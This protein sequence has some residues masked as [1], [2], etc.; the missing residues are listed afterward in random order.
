MEN[1]TPWW[2]C[3]FGDEWNM[4]TFWAKHIVIIIWWI[5]WEARYD[6]VGYHTDNFLVPLKVYV[7]KHKTIY[8]IFG[9][10]TPKSV[11]L[12][13]ETSKGVKWVQSRINFVRNHSTCILL[14]IFQIKAPLLHNYYET[15]VVPFTSNSGTS[16]PWPNYSFPWWIQESFCRY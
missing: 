15:V 9:M 10:A 5:L 12:W 1:L 2:A 14:Q 6:G 8:L 13:P 7:L 3:I 11:L 4:K 16:L